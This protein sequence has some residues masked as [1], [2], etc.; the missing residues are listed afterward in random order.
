MAAGEFCVILFKG[1]SHAVQA[2]RK[3]MKAEINVR[4]I[5]VPREISSSC[6]V[7]LRIHSADRDAVELVM[8]ETNC[9]FEEIRVIGFAE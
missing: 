5:P 7:C 1:S 8:S 3:C 2:E 9:E 6:G 4:L